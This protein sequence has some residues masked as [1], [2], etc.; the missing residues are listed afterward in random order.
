MT[1]TETYP[2]VLVPEGMVQVARRSP[3]YADGTPVHGDVEQFVWWVVTSWMEIIGQH[4]AWMTR[5]PPPAKADMRF[6]LANFDKFLTAWIADRLTH[7][8]EQA[9]L[10]SRP[11]SEWMTPTSTGRTT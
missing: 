1:T 4:F 7:T 3:R 5:H 10:Q 9:V 2:P 6:L 8:W 11:G